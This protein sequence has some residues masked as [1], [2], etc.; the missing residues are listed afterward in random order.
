LTGLPFSLEF[1]ELDVDLDLM[2]RN[3]FLISLG[4][5]LANTRAA[6]QPADAVTPEDA[7]YPK[8]RIPVPAIERGCGARLS[9]R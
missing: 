3:L 5:D 9:Q 1:Q 4:V 8:V 7:I 6:G 2:T